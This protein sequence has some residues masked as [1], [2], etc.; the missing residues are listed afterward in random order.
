[1]A[2]SYEELPTGADPVTVSRVDGTDVAFVREEL[3]GDGAIVLV[4]SPAEIVSN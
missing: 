4:N 3:T 1:M 2:G